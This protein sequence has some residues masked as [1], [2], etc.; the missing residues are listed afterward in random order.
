MTNGIIRLLSKISKRI[1]GFRFVQNQMLKDRSSK[2][3]GVNHGIKLRLTTG[4]LISNYIYHF[5]TWEPCITD[6]LIR[7]LNELNGRS[8]VDIGA[9]IGYFSILVAKNNPSCKVYSFEPTPSIFKQLKENLQLNE[10]SNVSAN[11]V[12]LSNHEGNLRLYP[13]HPMNS[14]S[15][16]IFRNEE[17]SESFSV[18]AS[19]LHKEVVKMPL[20]PRIVKI[21]TEGSESEILSHLRQLVELLPADVEFIVE[22]NPELIGLEKANAII[23]RFEDLNFNSFQIKNSYELEFYL[24][25][26]DKDHQISELSGPLES[27]AD[28]LFTR[29]PLEEICH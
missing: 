22:I 15:T 11:Q 26:R 23:R 2:N 27:Q 29:R 9:N 5:K 19:T 24:T 14:G 21:D 6:Y 13:G 12:A 10:L 18:K 4:D 28:V 20:P 17:S 3:I 7:N 25:K 16:G 1:Y 8:F